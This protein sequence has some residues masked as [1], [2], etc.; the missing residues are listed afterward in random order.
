MYQL[1]LT[2]TQ[3]PTRGKLK[4][5]GLFGSQFKE[6]QS[7][8]KALQ[9][10]LR[11]LLTLPAVQLESREQAGNRVELS[12]LKAI[13]QRL[14]NLPKQSHQQETRHSGTRACGGGHT[15]HSSYTL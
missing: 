15:S 11:Q 6:I 4:R 1:L 9:K 2:V 3:Y 8:G 14:Y 12:N 5:K 10:E 7:S 13:P